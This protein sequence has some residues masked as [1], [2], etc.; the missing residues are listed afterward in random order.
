MASPVTVDLPHS[1]GAQEAKR[2]MEDGIGK[3]ADFIPGGSAEVSHAWSGD[4]MNLNVR[5]MGQEVKAT[6]GVE[7][8]LVRLEL[9]L[10][11]ALAF[12][13]RHIEGLIRR[14]GTQMLEDKSDGK[15]R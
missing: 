12:F 13:G 6:I 5:A 2:R 4:R 10:P 1:L 7:E 8:R 3:L 9:L 15:R 14:Q 11:P